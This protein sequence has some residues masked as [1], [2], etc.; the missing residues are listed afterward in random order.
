MSCWLGDSISRR[1]PSREYSTFRRR[2]RNRTLVQ[3]GEM[4][5]SRGHRLTA[6]VVRPRHGWPE[7]ALNGWHA[8]S[9]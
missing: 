9:S 2:A 4:L 3:G 6:E 1:G 7:R 5:E 8:M